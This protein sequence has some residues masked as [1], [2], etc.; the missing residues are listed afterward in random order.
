MTRRSKVS[1]KLPKARRQ[2]AAKRDSAPTRRRRSSGGD[3]KNKIT[4]VNR[5]RDEALEQLSAASEV[6]KVISSS[7]GDL[8]PVFDTILENATRLCEA[9]FGSML[10]C[11]GDSYRRATVHN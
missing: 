10:L 8:K 11:E 5:E 3:Q 9:T 7:A 6:L 2:A 4:Q 1:G